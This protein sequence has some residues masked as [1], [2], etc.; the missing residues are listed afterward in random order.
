MFRKILIANRGEI[1]LRVIRACREMGIRSVIVHSEADRD[2]LPVR[3]ADE[4]IC[5]GPGPSGKSYLNIPNII[6]AA[7]ISNAEAIHPGYGFLSENTS[8]AEICK[9][10]NITFI[11]PSASVMSVMG[12]KVSAR[13][14]MIK[15][16]L[17]TLP[18]TPVLRTL[19]EAQDAAR[20]I[21]FPLMLKAV[22]GG[23]GRG[24][25]LIN[26]PE[27]FDR[28]FTVAQNEVREAFRD[29]GIYLERY[30]AKARHVE[31]QVLVDNYGHGVHL[32]E[33]NCSCQRRNQKVLEESPS[34]IL[35]RELC[36]E[37]GQKA[38]RAVQEV[39]YRNAGTLEFLVD[40]QNRYYFM[41]MN[42]RLQVEHPVTELV[43]GI[44]LVKEQIRIASGLPL[45]LKQ[46]D[47][48]FRG[49]AI[50]VRIT[51]EDADADFRPQTG[52]V[53]NYQVPG[54]PGV[55]VDSHLY[56][57]YEIPPHY[58]SLLSKLIV[59][60]ETRNEAIARM[61]RALDE[62]EIEGLTTTIPFHKRLL[63]HEGFIQ[64]D[65]YTRFIQ[66]EATAL[67]IG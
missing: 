37:M 39:G 6:S 51:A 49:H 7:L 47:I 58:D 28:V 59:W 12:D 8:F 18:G 66:E 55:R 17:P 65:T 32:G 23:G 25:R 2:S 22:A 50:E 20:E 48:K 16:G 33:R 60:A 13:E 26:K 63:S 1:A 64:G 61:Q 31:I 14:A 24:I 35:P 67:G 56:S 3:Q 36:E 41:E 42:T 54:G 62:Y 44:D 57:G 4:R 34:P 15:A 45:Q 52:V 29:D 21:G 10:V 5:I 40:E 53:E 11:G 19:S 9:D 43:T 38:I 27:E 46:E 30:V